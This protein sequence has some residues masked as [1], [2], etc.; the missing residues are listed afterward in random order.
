MMYCDVLK[1]MSDG[2]LKVYV[3]GT[4]YH[5]IEGGRI[6]YVNDWQVSPAEKWDVKKT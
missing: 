2:R 5:S 4:R 1:T 3:Y 6:R